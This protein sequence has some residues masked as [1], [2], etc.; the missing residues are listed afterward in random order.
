MRPLL[1]LLLACAP[2]PAETPSADTGFTER[3]CGRPRCASVT[4]TCYGGPG[5]VCV[6][7]TLTCVDRC[8]K[9]VVKGEPVCATPEPIPLEVPR[10]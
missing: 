9:T 2:E 10:G 6:C 5:L 1:L 3:R 4:E 7:T 8:G